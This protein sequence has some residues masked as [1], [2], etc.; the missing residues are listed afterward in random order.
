MKN[1]DFAKIEL[2]TLKVTKN[3]MKAKD[4]KIALEIVKKHKNEFI[5]IWNEWFS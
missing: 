2:E 1:D 4:L 5:R 3:Y